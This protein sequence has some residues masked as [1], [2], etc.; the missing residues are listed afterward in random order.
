MVFFMLTIYCSYVI[1]Y[2]NN[3][4]VQIFFLDKCNCRSKG[5]AMENLTTDV[6]VQAI[7]AAALGAIALTIGVQKLLKDW[8]STS[9]ETSVIELM[10]TELER[11][12]EQN[13]IL[14]RELNRLQQEIITL[15]QQLSRLAIEN[16]NLHR[17]IA[18]LTAEI[19]MF[20]DVAAR[21]GE[22]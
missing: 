15:N 20:K 12:S 19:A 7:S 4:Q 5:S 17:E 1:I 22:L 2:Q 8:K 11:M 9:A 14:S 18:A 3:H 21:K 6:L 16:Q 10:H 13:S